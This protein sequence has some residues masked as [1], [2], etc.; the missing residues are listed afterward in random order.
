LYF[1]IKALSLFGVFSLITP[2]CNK[3]I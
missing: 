3:S 1:L 2:C